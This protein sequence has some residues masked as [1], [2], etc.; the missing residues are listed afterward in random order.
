[1]LVRSDDG[2]D[3]INFRSKDYT[4]FAFDEE[5]AYNKTDTSDSGQSTVAIVLISLI[6][7][8]LIIATIG[9]NYIPSI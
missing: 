4:D 1:M 8:A 7:I 2:S 3:I 5:A 9:N 6:A